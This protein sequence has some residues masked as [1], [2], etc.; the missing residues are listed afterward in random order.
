[1]QIRR[2]GPD[3]FIIHSLT[4]CQAHQASQ[5]CYP[6]VP[7]RVLVIA[8]QA[9]VPDVVAFVSA[10]A[11][12]PDI[13]E[14]AWAPAAL[15]EVPGVADA[16]PGLY[17]GVALQ[18]LC[19]AAAEPAFRF[20]GSALASAFFPGLMDSRVADSPLPVFLPEAERFCY[21]AQALPV[22]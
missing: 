19:F 18:A 17:Y 1:M 16:E 10:Q 8:A 6:V 4:A 20:F 21:L 2:F 11:V 7:G 3:K 15:F 5:V 12:E 14:Q 9:G 13:A 22:D